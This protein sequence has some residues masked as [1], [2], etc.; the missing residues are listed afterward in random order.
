MSKPSS[1][2]SK[3]L[4]IVPQLVFEPLKTPSFI[5]G[6]WTPYP[7]PECT[8]RHTQGVCVSFTSQRFCSHQHRLVCSHRPRCVCLLLY[9]VSP[10]EH[11][12][13]SDI[14]VLSRRFLQEQT[15][16]TSPQLDLLEKLDLLE[17]GDIPIHLLWLFYWWK[18]YDL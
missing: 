2:P 12:S 7:C 14:H 13:R 3:P 1:N 5:F 15:C 8:V 10:G 6:L 16:I 11:T 18:V 9:F 4:A 17:Q